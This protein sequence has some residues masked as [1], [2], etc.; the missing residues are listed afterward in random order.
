MN[1]LTVAV[2]M[3]ASFGLVGNVSA[4]DA[5]SYHGSVCGAYY[6]NQA[7]SFRRQSSG[8][9]NVSNVSRWVG[10]PVT[11]DRVAN[12]TGAKDIWVGWT[13]D[14]AGQKFRCTFF[15]KRYNGT[16]IDQE[17]KTGG[18][19]LHFTMTKDHKYGAYYMYCLLPKGATLNTIWVDEN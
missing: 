5:K 7:S 11:Q 4:I 19:S 2:L 12:T 8:F 13:A 14:G 10:C 3:V 9:K 6:G 16:N 1:H 17:T 18:G 15:S